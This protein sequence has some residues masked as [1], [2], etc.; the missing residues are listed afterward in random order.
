MQEFQGIV[1][2]FWIEER[3]AF[4]LLGDHKISLLPYVGQNFSI[5][6]LDETMCLHCHKMGEELT[7]G[8]CPHCVK[9][10]AHNDLCYVVP[11][12]C[13]FARGSCREPQWS[14][15]ICFQEH[16]LYLSQTS[17]LKVGITRRTRFKERLLEQ[18]AWQGLSLGVFPTR[19]AAGKVEKKLS[20]FIKDKTAWKKML[21]EQDVA[22]I[23]LVSEKEKL[24][25]FLGK[26][27]QEHHEHYT[28]NYPRLELEK[29]S[30]IKLEIGLGISSRLLG[31]RGHYI[32]L[33]DGFIHSGKLLGRKINLKIN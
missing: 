4:L 31:A 29:T 27:C 3:N 15:H 33:S 10:L 17:D 6:I 2:D 14:Q 8:E 26:D 7:R 28:F 21:T 30:M 9:R 12:L 32:I 11:S 18:G 24:T 22:L 23:D 25:S 13:H 5:D 19:M 16:I 1:T 20:E